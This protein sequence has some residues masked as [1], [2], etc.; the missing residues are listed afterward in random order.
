MWKEG[1]DRE[2]IL[3]FVLDEVKQNIMICEWV[4][5]N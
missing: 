4:A 2:K 1:K 3:K 5:D